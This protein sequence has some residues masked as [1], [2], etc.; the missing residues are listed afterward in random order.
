MFN[1]LKGNGS[2]RASGKCISGFECWAKIGG[3]ADGVMGADMIPKVVVV[4]V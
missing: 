4:G 3:Q 1:A 2:R